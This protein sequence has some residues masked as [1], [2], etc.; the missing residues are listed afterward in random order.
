MEKATRRIS[1][2]FPSEDFRLLKVFCAMS[3]I[4]IKDCVLESVKKLIE[5]EQKKGG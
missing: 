2:D 1:I 5:K 3:G 4:T